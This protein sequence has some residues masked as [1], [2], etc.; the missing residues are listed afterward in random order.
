VADR[1]CLRHAHGQEADIGLA[2]DGRV[3]ACGDSTRL[4][5][6]QQAVFLDGYDDSSP[7]ERGT[8]GPI[9]STVALALP[10][11]RHP[12]QRRILQ[13]SIVRWRPMLGA[14]CP[15]GLPGPRTDIF[16]H[17]QYSS[18]LLGG[19]CAAT[20]RMTTIGRLRMAARIYFMGLECSPNSLMWRALFVLPLGLV[21]IRSGAACESH[22]LRAE[23]HY[24]GHI[25]A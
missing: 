8:R 22:E 9:G 19:S 6:T 24:E 15:V 13:F 7:R 5:F 17:G 14:R 4:I 10:R 20:P 2:G 11:P 16:A 23:R 3:K 1:V 21:A 18:R 25:G 12:P